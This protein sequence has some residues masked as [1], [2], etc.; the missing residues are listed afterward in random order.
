MGGLQPPHAISPLIE[1]E[2]WDEDQT[3]AWDVV[4]PMIPKLTSLSHILTPPG[5]VKEKK[6]AISGFTVFANNFRTKKSSGIIQAPSC[7]SLQ[8]ASKHILLTSEGQVENLTSG[9][10][11]MMIDLS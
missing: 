2:L 6:I 3:N 10:S 11:N 8:D 4:S 7:F 9:Q 5:R 1:I